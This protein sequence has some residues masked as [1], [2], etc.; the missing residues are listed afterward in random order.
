VYFMIEWRQSLMFIGV[1]V[2]LCVSSC[3]TCSDV[4]NNFHRPIVF[5]YGFLILQFF[6]T[7]GKVT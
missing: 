1:S 4:N 3:H 2:I 7:A 6:D 5:N